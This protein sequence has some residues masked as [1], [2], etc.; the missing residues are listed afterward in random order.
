MDL[1]VLFET[2]ALCVTVTL[3]ADTAQQAAEAQR[4][5]KRRRA[6]REMAERQQKRLEEVRQQLNQVNVLALFILLQIVPSA[7]LCSECQ[8][9]LAPKS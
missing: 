5:K 1:T 2:A 8:L 9:K 7:T 4:E 6:A 3:C